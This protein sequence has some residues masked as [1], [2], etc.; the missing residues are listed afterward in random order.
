MKVF[1]VLAHPEPKS[2]THSLNK[3]FIEELKKEG[4]EVK[5]SDLYEM[6]WNPV[7]DTY[8]APV[9]RPDGKFSIAR[10][11]KNAYENHVLPEDVQKEQDKVEWAD[12]VVFQ[13]PLWW[14]SAPAI[15]KGWIDRVWAAGYA[16]SR[17]YNAKTPNGERY[18]DGVFVGKKAMIISTNG[19]KNTCFTPRG[20]NGPI[21]D[22]LFHQTHGWFFYGGFTVLPSLVL[23]SA[24]HLTDPE[25]EK[26]AASVRQ[27]AQEVSTLEP[28]KF[29][30]Q[31][32]GDYDL[33]T[34]ELKAGLE[35]PGTSGFSLHIK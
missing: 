13:Y 31:N 28:I 33:E 14:F 8:D 26:L 5:V 16:Y 23:Y 9:E 30:H 11:Q 25:Y 10:D 18:G 19:S 21:D 34:L 35:T 6:K 24:N 20:I 3:V 2:L 29:R 27:R 22:V 4:H 32:D 17:G 1:I 7:L 12:L 15:V